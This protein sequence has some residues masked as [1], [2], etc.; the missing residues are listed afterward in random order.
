MT[1]VVQTEVRWI[2]KRLRPFVRLHLLSY[3]CVV[4]SSVLAL[5]D[6]LF[7]R[8][9]IDTIIPRGK[10]SWIVPVAT[11]FFLTYATRFTL[12]SLAGTVI[13]RISQMFAFKVRLNLL[14]KLQRLSLDYHEQRSP[15]EMLHRLQ[16]DVEQVATLSGEIVPGILR[17]FTT[18]SLVIVL[19]LIFNRWLTLAVLP[20]IPLFVIVRKRFYFKLAEASNQA[21]AAAGLVTQFLDEHLSAL[22]QIQ[23]LS[24]EQREARRFAQISSESLR[25]Q[26][27]RRMTEMIFGAV[28]YL[29]IIAG[30]A[31]VLGYGSYQVISGR[32]TTGSL[33]AFY[34]Y[35]LQLFV[36]FYGAVDLYAKIQRVRASIRRLLE[37]SDVEPAIQ[38]KP[39]ASRLTKDGPARVE[40]LDVTFGYS[41]DRT[42]LDRVSL[43]IECGERV[44][45][46]GA[47]GK[48]KSTLAR[49]LARLCDPSDGQVLIDGIDLREV[50]L[51]SLRSTLVLVPQEP[52]L[53]DLTLRENLLRGNVNASQQEL[54]E[55]IR[56][57]QLEKVVERLPLGLDESLGLKGAKLSGGERQ[58]VALAR[59]I[60]QRPRILV[61][62]ESTSALDASTE[63][64]LL[65]ALDEYLK[66]VTVVVISHREFPLRW[67]D[68][69][70]HVSGSSPANARLQTA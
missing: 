16:V 40:L 25:R 24:C 14:R 68:R 2:A 15:G 12:D 53:F 26:Y 54:D 65:E 48:G 17:I 9:L 45:I 67:A 18:F 35:T 42:I 51:R 22:V 1:R 30:I 61:L 39:D 55:A 49:L 47:S 44:A 23:L 66:D 31:T 11:A 63:K 50:G 60:L 37:I 43:Q 33:V 41:P 10:L 52:I 64:L 69:T 34:G 58:R 56:L 29:I 46:A 6:P 32:L 70:I 59:A 38:D 3:V 28:L 20:L 21:Q 7:V 27:R 57:T 13:F 36:P 19:M 4:S 62:D 8:L 5:V